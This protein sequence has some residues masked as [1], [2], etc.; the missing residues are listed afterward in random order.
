MMASDF[1]PVRASQLFA[2]VGDLAFAELAAGLD[3]VSLNKGDV[4]VRQGESVACVYLVVS[5]RLRVLGH[6]KRAEPRLLF[7]ADVGETICE[8]ALLSDDPSFATV[9][10]ET[11]TTVVALSRRHSTDFQ[12]GIPWQPCT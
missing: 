4:L 7:Y 5:G 8:M 1:D 6:T 9:D 12:I 11:D 3:T 2:D 10:A